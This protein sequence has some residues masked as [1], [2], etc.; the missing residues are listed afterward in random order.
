[1]AEAGMIEVAD[2]ALFDIVDTAEAGWQALTRRGLTA[3]AD[4]HG[5]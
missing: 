5:I 4:S 2:L 3:H 1:M